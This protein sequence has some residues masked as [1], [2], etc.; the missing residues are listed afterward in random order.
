MSPAVRE[1]APDGP[2]RAGSDEFAEAVLAVVER[3][4]AG[5]VLSYGDVAE[6]LGYGGPRS[7]GR[8]MATR[9]SGVPW[10]RVVRAD[11]SVVDGLAERANRHHRDE[12]TPLRPDGLRVDMN[13]AR[14]DG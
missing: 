5:H 14:W 8:V 4:P 6:Y 10:W 3:I 12:G 9:G 2:P 11:G 13:R 1:P 7:V